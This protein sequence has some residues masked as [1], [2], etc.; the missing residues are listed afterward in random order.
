MTEPDHNLP[1]AAIIWHSL[2]AESL[3]NL[4]YSRKWELAHVS[5]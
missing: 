4:F 5:T 1:V 2:C 3:I